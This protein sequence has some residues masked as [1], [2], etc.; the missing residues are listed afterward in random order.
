[1]KIRMFFIL[2]V[3]TLTSLSC[4]QEAADK[5]SNPS[6]LTD[7]ESYYQEYPDT[8]ETVDEDLVTESWDVIFSFYGTINDGNAAQEDME[9]GSGY[10]TYLNLEGKSVTVND[11]V[12]AIKKDI[13]IS[14]GHSVPMIQV[15]FA[16]NPENV[17]E[18]GYVTYYILQLEGA[19]LAKSETYYL[20]NDKLF[21]AN[22]E[23]EA[24][25]IKEICYIEEPYSSRGGVT[26]FTNNIRIGEELR[27][28]GEADMHEM[29]VI[30]CKTLN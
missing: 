8:E 18:E 25:A 24:G 14:S 20:N 4:I 23:L 29:E 3:V 28:E 26:I 1:M 11:S 27:I 10:L 2:L 30:E 16:D 5:Y 17:S 22:V 19:S 7:T 12:W 15:F 21:K 6:Y 13:T 9:L